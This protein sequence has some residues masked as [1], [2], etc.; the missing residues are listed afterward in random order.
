MLPVL[1]LHGYF[2]QKKKKKPKTNNRDKNS[3]FSEMATRGTK[4]STNLNIHQHLH[5][6]PEAEHTQ[7]LRLTDRLYMM[8]VPAGSA[9]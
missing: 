9:L 8:S 5:L 2:W 1:L 6:I 7:C 4:P 3:Q